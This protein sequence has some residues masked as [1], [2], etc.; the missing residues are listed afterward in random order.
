MVRQKN[1]TQ[2]GS[3]SFSPWPFEKRRAFVFNFLVVR[4]FTDKNSGA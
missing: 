3:Q 2:K 1:N 4:E